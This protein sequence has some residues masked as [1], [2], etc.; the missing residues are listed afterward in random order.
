MDPSPRLSTLPASYTSWS[1]P[2][3]TAAWKQ[4]RTEYV[5]IVVAATLLCQ[6]EPNCSTEQ[7]GML[8]YARL[9]FSDG[10]DSDTND[11]IKTKAVPLSKWMTAGAF[12]SSKKEPDY[13]Y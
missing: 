11:R 4:M 10:F 3:G 1:A 12:V 9:L 5:P 2:I 7:A 8:R 13:G 6:K